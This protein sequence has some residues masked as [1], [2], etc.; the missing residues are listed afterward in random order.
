MM[1]ISAINI[2]SVLFIMC[3]HLPSLHGYF[4]QQ[5]EAK[6]ESLAHTMHFDIENTKNKK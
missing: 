5:K 2:Y 6:N 3:Q 4:Q 1:L